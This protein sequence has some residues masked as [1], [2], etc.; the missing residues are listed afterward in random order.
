VKKTKAA[1]QKRKTRSKQPV[2]LQAATLRNWKKLF[3]ERSLVR[4]IQ[5]GIGENTDGASVC[6]L[7][8]NE[9]WIAYGRKCEEHLDALRA[10]SKNPE[11][12]EKLREE[13]YHHAFELGEA[14][15]NG[16]VGAAHAM[17]DLLV[18]FFL[19]RIPYPFAGLGLFPETARKGGAS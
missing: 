10:I 14:A 1:G 15:F 18:G 12:S 5:D 19:P 9:E 3:K 13:I 8:A 17:F 6:D 7:A 2:D 16:K 11:L 4:I